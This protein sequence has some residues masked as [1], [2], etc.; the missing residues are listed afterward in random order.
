MKGLKLFQFHFLLQIS[1]YQVE[2][3]TV[4]FLRQHL[5]F[6]VYLNLLQL[7]HSIF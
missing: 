5:I 4:L 3:E 2:I 6:V 7:I 1:T